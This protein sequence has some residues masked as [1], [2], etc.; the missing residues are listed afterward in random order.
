MGLNLDIGLWPDYLAVAT[1][2]DPDKA[3]LGFL[4]PTGKDAGTGVFTTLHRTGNQRV[5]DAAVWLVVEYWRTTGQAMRSGDIARLGWHADSRDPPIA[6]AYAGKLGAGG[7]EVDLQA[8]LDV[9]ATALLTAGDRSH[10]GW[11]QLRSR[12][13]QPAGRLARL[14]VPLSGTYDADGNPIPSRRHHPITPKRTR[15]TRFLRR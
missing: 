12:R 13:N 15:P 1:L 7:R 11:S 4:R 9:C 10:D 14:T 2:G 6:D 5:A 3:A 8:A